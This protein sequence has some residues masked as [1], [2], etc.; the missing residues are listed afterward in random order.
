MKKMANR[1]E[2]SASAAERSKVGYAEHA[3][4]PI[5]HFWHD[6]YLVSLQCVRPRG[7]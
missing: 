4:L 7:E 5:L 6:Y 3:S 1:W 2:Q